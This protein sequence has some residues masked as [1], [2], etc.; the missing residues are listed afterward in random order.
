MCVAERAWWNSVYDVLLNTVIPCLNSYT[1]SEVC[2][3]CFLLKNIRSPATSLASMDDN[4]EVAA[5]AREP[6]ALAEAPDLNMAGA[7]LHDD[8]RGTTAA[9][10]LNVPAL[11]STARA[12]RHHKR[13]AAAETA[14][15]QD[16]CG[17]IC[18]L[19]GGTNCILPGGTKRSGTSVRS[20]SRSSGTQ[21]PGT[22]QFY[23][24]VGWS[25]RLTNN[26]RGGSSRPLVPHF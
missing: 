8:Q 19:P 23:L 22:R 17:A 4:E 24:A 1:W 6:A 2:R 13:N 26:G 15:Q 5:A 21:P 7:T 25:L 3:P 18:I 20:W 11:A 10:V 12:Q 16:N 9:V 14:R